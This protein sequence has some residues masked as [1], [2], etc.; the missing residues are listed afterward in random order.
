MKHKLAIFT[1]LIVFSFSYSENNSNKDTKEKMFPKYNVSNSEIFCT[2]KWTKRGELDNRMYHYCLEREEEGWFEAKNL[3][4]NYINYPWIDSL[5]DFAIQKWTKRG[6]IQYRM[7]A[8]QMNLE[9]EGYLDIE[10]LKNNN[11]INQSTLE[12]CSNKW[13]IQFR[14]VNYCIEK[15]M[16]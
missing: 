16:K 6:V 13:G 14:M 5:L 9:I 12:Y 8:Y 15:E 11:K 3:Y 7:V 2:D 4:N 10:Y 1:L